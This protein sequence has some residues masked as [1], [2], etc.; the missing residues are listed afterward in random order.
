MTMATTMLPLQIQPTTTSS[1]KW[2]A[3][4][5]RTLPPTLLPFYYGVLATKI[6]C[7][8]TCTARLA[9]RANVIYFSSPSAA[10]SSGYRACKRCR[11]DDQLFLG[12]A[13]E[14]VMKAMEVIGKYGRKQGLEG[15]AVETGVSKSYLCRVFKKT[16]GVTVGEYIREFEKEGQGFVDSISVDTQ[17]A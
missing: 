13:E 8:P 11:P 2:H 6:Y 15:I 1:Q 7:R 9:R 3:L 17:D 14:V 5:T 16:M 12:E 10:V 4:T